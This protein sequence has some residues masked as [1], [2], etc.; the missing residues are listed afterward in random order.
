M[1][2][3]SPRRVLLVEKSVP[4]QH[5]VTEILAQDGYDVT[6]ATSGNDAL[7]RL[8]DGYAPDVIFLAYD[9]D[10]MTGLQ[11]FHIYQFGVSNP[12]PVFFITDNPSASVLAQLRDSGVTEVINKPV[13]SAEIIAAMVKTAEAQQK[14]RTGLQVV[15]TH[16]GDLP[17]TAHTSATPDLRVVPMRYLDPDVIAE[18]DAIGRR[19]EFLVELFGH[20]ITDIER[21]TP[22]LGSAIECERWAD[23][24]KAAHALKGVAQQMG[25]IQLA[26][27][28]SLLIQLEG[29]VSASEWRR[30]RAELS[31]ISAKTIEALLEEQAEATR[32]IR[33]KPG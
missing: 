22:A 20:A 30:L 2:P 8:A 33:I 24:R 19:P 32:K 17:A 27:I 13:R 14:A 28:A 16:H 23:I 25:A 26:R 15:A 6:V 21:I 11:V 3:A 9:L 29:Q 31:S 1:P 7:T 18:L 10:D 4:H 12:A 5:L